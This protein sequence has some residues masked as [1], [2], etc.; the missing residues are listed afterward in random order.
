[1]GMTNWVDILHSQASEVVGGY[2][3]GQISCIT[4]RCQIERQSPGDQAN[5]FQDVASSSSRA[6]VEREGS[7]KKE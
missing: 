3:G 7:T 5:S 1:M 6:E 2:F 4:D